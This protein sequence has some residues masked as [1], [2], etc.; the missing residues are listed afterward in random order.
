[1]ST[2]ERAIEI[3][4]ASHANQIARCGNPYILHPLRVMLAV[5]TTE[6]QIAAALHDLVGDTHVTLEDLAREGFS[7][8]IVEAVSAL[9]K[10]EGESRI[11]AARRAAAHPIAL[12]VK[13]ADTR[14]NMD[15]KRIAEP[16]GKDALRLKEYHEV[17]AYLIAQGAG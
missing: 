14:D 9:T 8:H 11:D 17:C 3:A 15:L 13:L 4:A 10:R 16:Y 1:M 7:S 5:K 12:H 2:L 6:Q